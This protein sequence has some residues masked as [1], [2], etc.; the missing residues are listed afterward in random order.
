MHVLILPSWYPRNSEDIGGSFFREQAI[1]LR[2]NGCKVGVIHLELRSIKSWMSIFNGQKNINIE[3]DNGIQT[4]R[5]HG[6]N[7]FPRTHSATNKLIEW[8]GLRVYKQYVRENGRPDVVHVHSILNAG[9]IA[10]KIFK[11]EKISY[12]V[13][14]HSSIFASGKI[15][16]KKEKMARKI[17][18]FAKHR[19][20]V[21]DEFCKL[22]NKK[23]GV[24]N[25]RWE[26]MP[27]SVSQ[28]FIDEPLNNKERDHF[29][30]INV[31]LMNE[32]KMQKNIIYA[33]SE[34]RKRWDV[35]LKIVGD[36]PLRERLESLAKELN[37]QDS[38]Q[39]TGML[40]R[41]QVMKSISEADAFVLSSRYETFGVVIIEALA[42]GKP[43][44]ATRCGGP[45]SI[46]E[47]KDGILV[48]V[49]D[50]NALSAAM[51]ELIVQKEKYNPI[52]IRESCIARYSEASISRRLIEI[53]ASIAKA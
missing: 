30:F 46:V 21:S 53:Y 29:K 17:A 48:P 45:E 50:V 34:I 11:K 10:S 43:V 16:I 19:F 14:E 15:D 4:Y 26:K 13:T 33:F 27:N 12:V 39:F 41:D 40:L 24:A 47:D 31:A 42:L 8:Y 37:I 18:I 7:W 44:I 9:L 35:R 25:V 23:I 52:A 6:I 22:L 1:A 49:D 2:K 20:A 36:G 3:N 51:E 38:V 32:N 28:T 5:A